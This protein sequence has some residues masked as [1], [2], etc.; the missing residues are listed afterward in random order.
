MA[1]ETRV[2]PR[3]LASLHVSVISGPRFYWCAMEQSEKMRFYSVKEKVGR[4]NGQ[5]LPVG[6]TGVKGGRAGAV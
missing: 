4:L 6:D 1:T 5:L 3:S 2:A